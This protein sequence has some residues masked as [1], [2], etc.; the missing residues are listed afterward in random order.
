MAL[1]AEAIDAELRELVARVAAAPDR[2]SVLPAD[3]AQVRALTVFLVDVI[4]RLTERQ[5]LTEARLQ[6][7][8][9]RC[10]EL[11]ARIEALEGP[12]CP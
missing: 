1:L 8:A 4:D 5:E 11:E 3:V 7:M 10:M 12:P 2:P 9:A 6:G